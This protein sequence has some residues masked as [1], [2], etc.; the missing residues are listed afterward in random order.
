MIFGISYE[1]LDFMVRLF[2]ATHLVSSKLVEDCR[3]G[4]PGDQ[5]KLI[6]TSPNHPSR[7]FRVIQLWDK[8]TDIDDAETDSKGKTVLTPFFTRDA[9]ASNR[10]RLPARRPTPLKI[11]LVEETRKVEQGHQK[12]LEEIKEHRARQ[13]E[14]SRGEDD[15][16]DPL[17]E[18]SIE[19]FK[20]RVKTTL[21]QK[22]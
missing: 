20:K 3:D 10:R 8:E 15:G 12:L 18:E 5:V 11:D 7:K 9:R 2:L 4:L 21:H 13:P 1:Y 19:E 16:L 6:P 14:W 17:P 22:W